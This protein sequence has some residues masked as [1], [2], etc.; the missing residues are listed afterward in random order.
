MIRVLVVDDTLE[1]RRLIAAAMKHQGYEV[2]VA[3]GGREALDIA[4]AVD[5]DVILLDI[6][7]PEISGLDVLKGLKEHE[8]TRE[9]PVILVSAMGEDRDV[10]TGLD[11]GAHDYVTKPFQSAMLAARV[12]SAIRSKQTRDEVVRLNRQLQDEMVERRRMEL[13]LLHAQKLES[14]G[15]LAAG[16]AHEIN[17]PAQYVG[18]NLRYLQD[19]FSDMNRLV[20][21]LLDLLPETS[22]RQ[23]APPEVLA[24]VEQTIREADV[25]FLREETPRAIDQAIDGVQR[26]A[27]IVRAMKEFSHSGK[28]DRVPIDLNR[29]IDNVLTVSRNEWNSVA[30]LATDY[31]PRIPAVPC[32]PG[33]IHQ[34]ILHLV[35]NAAQAIA[36]RIDRG[37]LCRGA[38]AIQTRQAGKWAE[39]RVH[40]NGVGIPQRHRGQVFEPFFT[41]RDVGQGKG[42]GLTIARAIVVQKHHGMISFDSEEGVGTTFIVQ[43][44]TLNAPP[45][46]APATMSPAI[47]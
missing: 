4:L 37:E 42:H 30:E 8:R 29:S 40:D 46:T 1:M 26:V 20:D 38:I 9:I 19:A 5:L 36:A 39:I 7:M 45:P 34:V 18:D 47:A 3:S 35:V 22:A 14:M 21:A 43:L 31:D 28:E 23:G 41:T 15:R 2:F 33:D 12:R 13:E 44:P 17:T 16:I 6:M 25:G 24:R 32:C 10:I 27:Q 11:Q